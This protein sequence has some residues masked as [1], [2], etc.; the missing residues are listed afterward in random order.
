MAYA[1]MTELEAINEILM[2]CGLSPVN[3]LSLVTPEVEKAKKILTTTSRAVQTMGWSFNT[4]RNLKIT[5]DA[6]NSQ[7]IVPLN[8][9]TIDTVG[10]SAGIEVTQRGGILRKTNRYEGTDP[11]VFDSAVY[12]DIVY[13]LPFEEIPQ[14]GRWYI[15]IRAARRFADS[16]SASGTV[17]GF[18]REEEMYALADLREQEGAE[19]DYT[20]LD[21]MSYIRRRTL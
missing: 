12:V 20:M 15:T 8:A 9:L 16:F 6:T 13:Y 19:G 17:H 5:P 7:I 1:A 14:S 4:D 11:R 3:S 2:N 18:T 10:E 21:T